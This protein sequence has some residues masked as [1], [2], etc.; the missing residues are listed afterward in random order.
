MPSA[1][2]STDNR[3][4]RP[5]RVVIVYAGY[6]ARGGGVVQH[7]RQLHRHFEREGYEPIVLSLDSLPPGV[8]LLPHLVRRVVNVARSPWGTLLRYRI[9]RA[10]FRPRLRRLT[11][12]GDV[13]AVVFE[14]IYTALPLPVATLVVLHALETHNL[15]GFD[16][17]PARAREARRAEGRWLRAIE[18]PVVAVS[19]P[20]RDVVMADLAGA[21]A[22]CPRLGAVA[23]GIDVEPFP[24]PPAVRASARLELVFLGFLVAR[25]NLPFLVD[26][27]AELRERADFRLTIVGDGPYRAALRESFTRRGLDP[28]VTWLG[29]VAHAD[30]PRLLQQ[31]HV[32]VHPS[33]V[34]SF[35]YGLL[36]GRLSGLW[37]VATARLAVPPEFVDVELPLDAATWAEHIAKRRNAYTEPWSAERLAEIRDLRARYSVERMCAEYATLLG[38]KTR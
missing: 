19:G 38:L 9:G 15:Q 11:A 1:E 10:L 14:D 13:A 35:A 36:E 32:M 33:E 16:V 26:L 23:L 12:R 4:A 8:R 30:V 6:L 7:I 29:R 37:T 3:S 21:G 18:A 17:T 28:W 20:Y 5:A 24:S 22:A 27:A 31:F 2:P 34:E 25:K